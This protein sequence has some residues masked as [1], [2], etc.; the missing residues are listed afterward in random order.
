MVRHVFIIPRP[1]S[2]PPAKDS[3]LGQRPGGSFMPLANFPFLSK[4]CS[5]LVPFEFGSSLGAEMAALPIS[6]DKLVSVPDWVSETTTM[7][8]FVDL[9][10]CRTRHP[11]ANNTHKTHT[12]TILL[13]LLGR[14]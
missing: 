3:S 2:S 9:P 6:I 5:R 4:Q 10:G 7:L 13:F 12:A 1:R 14:C 11:I 8:D